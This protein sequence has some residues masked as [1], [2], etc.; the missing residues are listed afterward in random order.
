V[1][2]R[3]PDIGVGEMLSEGGGM[4]AADVVD[5]RRDGTG[6]TTTFVADNVRRMH[7]EG[8]FGGRSVSR[9]LVALA[10]ALMIEPRSEWE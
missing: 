1:C 6:G 10:V 8:S 5:G 2:L 7:S 3:C 4:V 9:L